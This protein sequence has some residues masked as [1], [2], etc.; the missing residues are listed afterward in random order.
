MQREEK[1]Y[2]FDI[3][4]AVQNIENFI[5]SPAVFE[6]F[7]QNFMLQQAVER[8]LEI[9]GE[10]INYLLKLNPKIKI[11]SARRMVTQQIKSF[12]VMMKSNQNM[13]WNIFIIHLPLLKQEVKHLLD[14]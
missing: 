1:K 13:V 4:T 3:Q 5:G 10:A 6:M 14:N 7:K 12:T 9:I 2:L 11:T 8:N